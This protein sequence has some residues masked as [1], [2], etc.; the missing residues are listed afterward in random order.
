[1]PRTKLS[2]SILIATLAITSLFAQQP[3]SPAA[4]PSASDPSEI[5]IDQHCRV[6]AQPVPTPANPNPRAG[7]HYNYNV[8]HLESELSS[9]HWDETMKNGVPRDAYVRIREREYVLHNITG[10][11]V[12]FVIAQ[13][14][15]KG[16]SIDS[17]PQ[18][19]EL[20]GNIAT[21][22]VT[23]QSNEIVRLHVGERH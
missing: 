6:L 8:C 19:T 15:S 16:W 23:A 12:T 22:R 7:F 10:T 14:L 5:H 17:D 20:N 2:T 11:P 13:P 18:P 1:M 4:A 3:G 9:S 21:F